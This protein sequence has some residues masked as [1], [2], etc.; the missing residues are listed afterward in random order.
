M[1]ACQFDYRLPAEAADLVSAL[2]TDFARFGGVIRGEADA[3]GFG[4]FSLPT[5]LGTFSG[6]YEIFEST[7]GASSVRIEVDEKPLFVPCS[8]IEEHLGRRLE[9]AAERAAEGTVA[10]A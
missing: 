7:P 5:P 6:T 10:G 1:A 2:K 4:E 9:K 3:G 8:A